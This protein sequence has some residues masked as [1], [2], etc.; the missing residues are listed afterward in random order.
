MREQAHIIAY[1]ISNSRRRTRVARYL[2]A[3]GVR[4][5]KSVFV[6]RLTPTRARQLR[7]ALESL[8]D[9]KADRLMMEPVAGRGFEKPE[10]LI[11]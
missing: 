1:D 2:E 4:V 5:Q 10:A 9:P 7:R 6:S 8:I 3:R 11:F